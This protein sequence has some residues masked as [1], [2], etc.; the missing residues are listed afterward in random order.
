MA[1]PLYWLVW[2]NGTPRKFTQRSPARLYAAAQKALGH[3]V[4]FKPVGFES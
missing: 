3:Q 4:I 1:K 2:V